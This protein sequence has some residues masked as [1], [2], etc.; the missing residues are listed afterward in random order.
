MSELSKHYNF[1]Y[2]G[3]RLDPYRVL[4]VYG[5]TDPAQQHAVKKLLRAGKSVKPLRQD[6][7]EVI[8]TLE[9]MLVMLTEDE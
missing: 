1:E 2:K 4:Q 5:I 6:I 9:R 3:I 8:L 7:Q